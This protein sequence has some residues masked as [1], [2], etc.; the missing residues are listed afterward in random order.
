VKS[1]IHIY[2]KGCL[3]DLINFNPNLCDEIKINFNPNLI[4]FNCINLINFNPQYVKIK[5]CVCLSVVLHL[6]DIDL[7]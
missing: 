1:F 5:S 3:E 6:H 4:N 7:P 2:K